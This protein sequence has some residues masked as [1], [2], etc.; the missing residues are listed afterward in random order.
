MRRPIFSARAG[1][2]TTV[3]QAIR[4][5]GLTVTSDRAAKVAADLEKQIQYHEEQAA[6]LAGQAATWRRREREARERENAQSNGGT[7][8]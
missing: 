5:A 4:N 3:E 7:K 2:G 8:Q 6:R 1:R